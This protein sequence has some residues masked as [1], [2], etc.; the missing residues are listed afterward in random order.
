MPVYPP[1][2]VGPAK[3]GYYPHMA[4]LDAAIWERFLDR[5]GG[6]FAQY[7]YDLALGGYLLDPDLGTPAERLGWRYSTAL[8]VDVTA[9]R[10][11]E[12]WLIEVRPNARTS[13]IGAAL[14]YS[15]MAEADEFSPWPLFPMVVTDSTTDD[16][17]YCA[18]RLG[19]TLIQLDRPDIGTIGP[20]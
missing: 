8:K 9:Q 15:I 2:W 1:E 17:S 20:P 18:Q 12:T 16:I 13:A 6:N 7:A 19:V 3:T 10:P 11:G 5:Y 4:K 14:C